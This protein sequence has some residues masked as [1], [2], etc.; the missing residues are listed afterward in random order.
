MKRIRSM[1]HLKASSVVFMIFLLVTGVMVFNATQSSS[2]D[3]S[4]RADLLNQIKTNIMAYRLAEM[5][6]ILSS[7]PKMK[8]EYLKR[9]KSV[10]L[11][12]ERNQDTI[13][14]LLFA[15]QVQTAF[16][17]FISD[18]EAYKDA[19]SAALSVA[20][21][22][23]DRR[24]IEQLKDVSRELYEK[25]SQSLEDLLEADKRAPDSWTDF[26]KIVYKENRL[27]FVFLFIWGIAIF[28]VLVTICYRRKVKKNS[29]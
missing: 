19:N 4:Q 21:G 28:F 13:E 6:L 3:R 8:E 10:E 9:I 12:L 23:S 7:S 5:E 25:A 16:K 26:V 11:Q 2:H 14:S 27:A 1:E 17:K 18:W 20:E 29:C 24:D 22:N 15:D